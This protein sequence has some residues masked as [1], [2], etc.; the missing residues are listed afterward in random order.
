MRRRV[1]RTRVRG[2]LAPHGL[3]VGGLVLAS[4]LALTGCTPSPR[5]APVPGASAS[6]PADPALATVFPADFTPASAKAETVRVADAI[7]A[8]LPA[9][10][11][12]HVDTAERLNPATT[13]GGANYGV[14]R[15]VSLDPTVD[16]VAIAKTMVQKIEASGWTQRQASDA[17]GVHLVTLTSNAK[18]NISWLLQ[19]SGDPRIQGQS[20]IQLQLISPDLP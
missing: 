18:P 17:S 15:I 10:I 6:V 5:A 3:L 1:L 16:P 19:L 11:V 14:L 12:T 4:V 20:V 7:V 2:G 9:S 13:D 8:L